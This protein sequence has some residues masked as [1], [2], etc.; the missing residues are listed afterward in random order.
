MEVLC[1]AFPHQYT[2]LAHN[3]T[4]AATCCLLSHSTTCYMC[5]NLPK[6]S[7]SEDSDL[8]VNYYSGE[9]MCA[10][11]VFWELP[12]CIKLCG[13]FASFLPPVSDQRFKN[14]NFDCMSWFYIESRLRVSWEDLMLEASKEI[15][16]NVIETLTLLVTLRTY[17]QSACPK[18]ASSWSRCLLS[19]RLVD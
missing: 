12:L 7:R 16:I 6:V 2:W 11:S 14:F 4:P 13:G 1:A 3:Q 5:R 18:A 15:N 9:A 19:Q 17:E 8:F 10:L